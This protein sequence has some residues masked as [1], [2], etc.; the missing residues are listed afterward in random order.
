MSTTTPAVRISAI[1]Q[2]AINV[3]DL[4]RATTFYQE[5]LGM[6][7]LF[8]LPKMAFFDCG[9]IRLMLALA[10]KPEFDHPAS[11]IYYKVDDLAALHDALAGQNVTFESPPHFVA[12]LPDHDLWM[13][14][15][16]DSEGNLI[17]LM[18]E[19]R[20]TAAAT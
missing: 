17:G 19:L 8:R 20:S 10:E 6:H 12:K 18:S 5:T 16:R 14:F 15:L 3:H 7:L 9:G 1:G 4:D 13:A 2:I 11:V